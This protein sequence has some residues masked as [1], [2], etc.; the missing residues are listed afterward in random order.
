MKFVK[1]RHV[2]PKNTRWMNF[3]IYH[4]AN[5]HGIPFLEGCPELALFVDSTNQQEVY[6]IAASLPDRHNSGCV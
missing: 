5:D 3:A 6:P 4:D 1:I 2:E